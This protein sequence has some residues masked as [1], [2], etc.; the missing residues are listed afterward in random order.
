GAAHSP[1]RDVGGPDYGASRLN[2]ASEGRDA[3]DDAAVLRTMGDAR[4]P[5]GRD[6]SSRRSGALAFP[7]L[8]HGLVLYLLSMVDRPPTRCC[9]RDCAAWTGG[10]R[11]LPRDSV[12]YDA[13]HRW[14]G[15]PN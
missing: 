9:V 11:G 8:V 1:Y 14:H 5:R 10:H 13:R 15:A 12:I 3:R 2:T 6:C 4:L 7:R